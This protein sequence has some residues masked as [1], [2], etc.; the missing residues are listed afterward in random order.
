MCGITGFINLSNES[1]SRSI[2]KKMTDSLYHRGPEGEGH[3]IFENFGIGHRRLS[4]IDLSNNASQPMVS[5]DKNWVISY[6]GEIYNFKKIRNNLKKLGYNFFSSG[7]TEVVLKSFIEWGE[8]CL[9]K[10]N[11]MF[12]FCIFNKKEK[13]LTLARDRFG[14]KPLY[15]L[16][17]KNHFLFSSEIKSFMFYPKTKLKIDNENLSE[18]LTFQN[19]I[20]DETLFKNVKI[21][22]PGSL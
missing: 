13:S 9:K 11:G 22:K 6:N 16:I 18:Y 7:D 14:I 8:E 17:N 4:I 5:E 1:A 19:F 15:Y 12:S 2:L 20:D 3:F 10:F 21:L